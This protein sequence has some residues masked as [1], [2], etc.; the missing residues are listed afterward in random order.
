MRHAVAVRGGWAAAGI[1]YWLAWTH[2]PARLRGLPEAVVARRARSR[3]P[4]DGAAV[5]V[6]APAVGM[7][8][9]AG[10]APASP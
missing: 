1:L 4:A 2:G 9:A 10:A 3:R 8:V 5:D 6:A 7:P